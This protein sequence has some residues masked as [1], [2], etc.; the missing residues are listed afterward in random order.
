METP[1]TAK[2]VILQALISGPAFGI[3]VIERVSKGSRGTL[4]LHQGSAYPALRALER[5]GL[6]RSW[7]GPPEEVRAGRPRRYYELTAAGL[8]T[9]RGQRDVLLGFLQPVPA[10]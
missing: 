7:E 3:E 4:R 5:A 8:R 6:V 10:R 1:L 9:A 2:A